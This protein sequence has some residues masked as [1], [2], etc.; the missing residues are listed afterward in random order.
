MTV[1]LTKICLIIVVI[2]INAMWLE[3]MDY[4]GQ[5]I[6][7]QAEKLLRAMAT[8]PSATQQAAVDAQLHHDLADYHRV[9]FGFATLCLVMDG[10]LLY[11]LRT[12]RAITNPA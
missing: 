2:Y 10:S 3:G 8:H 5:P 11:W 4:N 7:P 9:Y 12:R 1:K 6:S